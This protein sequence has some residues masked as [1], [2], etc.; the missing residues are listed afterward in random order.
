MK[1]PEHVASPLRPFPLAISVETPPGGLTHDV[2]AA[3]K[4]LTADEAVVVL[5]AKPG[6]N[7]HVQQVLSYSGVTGVGLTS[8]EL[9][10]VWA[11][12]GFDLMSRPDLP[13]QLRALAGSVQ[14]A[15]EGPLKKVFTSTVLGQ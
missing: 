1:L 15:L 10:R 14:A 7:L 2:A 12:M 5:I 3:Q 9:L 4:Q 8:V 13:P 11:S 6:E